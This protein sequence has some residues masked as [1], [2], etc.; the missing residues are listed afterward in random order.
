MNVN[1]EIKPN[2]IIY[3][4]EVIIPE[5]GGPTPPPTTIEQTNG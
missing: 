5:T 2:K 4:K 3:K 1:L